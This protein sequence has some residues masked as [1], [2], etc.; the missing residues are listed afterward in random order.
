MDLGLSFIVGLC[1]ICFLAVLVYHGWQRRFYRPH[2]LSRTQ[3]SLEIDENTIYLHQIASITEEYVY[4]IFLLAWGFLLGFTLYLVFFFFNSFS[5]QA[6]WVNIIL[7]VMLTSLG[8]VF[9]YI[10]SV[11]KKTVVRDSSGK[12]HELNLADVDRLEFKQEITKD[13]WN[14][15][16]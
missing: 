6:F 13:I 8:G 4:S 2:H 15:Y 1:I 7:A 3:V 5:E 10:A 16:K 14:L 11:D 12:K 9:A